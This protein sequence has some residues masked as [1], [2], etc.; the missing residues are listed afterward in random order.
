MDKERLSRLITFDDED[1]DTSTG[2]MSVSDDTCTPEH[3]LEYHIE[4]ICGD[5][6]INDESVIPE[7]RDNLVCFYE[8]EYIGLINAVKVL[9]FL[10][11]Y[12]YL[13]IGFDYAEDFTMAGVTPE[14]I[15]E[16]CKRARWFDHGYECDVEETQLYKEAAL[17]SD[18]SEYWEIIYDGLKDG[19]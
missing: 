7:I 5:F 9:K 15:L 13:T 2:Y 3:Y 11:R 1:T 10:N 8:A 12:P 16:V 14:D 17:Y 6:I 4:E 19:Q 18:D